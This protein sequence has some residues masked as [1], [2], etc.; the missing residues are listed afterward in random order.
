MWITVEALPLAEARPLLLSTVLVMFIREFESSLPS[1]R[2]IRAHSYI[3]VGFDS[4]L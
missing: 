1:I 2:V 4:L 3:C